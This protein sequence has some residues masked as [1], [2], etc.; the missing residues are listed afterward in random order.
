MKDRSKIVKLV[1]RYTFAVEQKDKVAVRHFTKQLRKYDKTTRLD[2][3]L[4]LGKQIFKLE[5]QI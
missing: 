5:E 2:Y 3:W 4:R 1:K